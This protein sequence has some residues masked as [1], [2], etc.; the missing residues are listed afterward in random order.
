MNNVDCAGGNSR[1]SALLPS[2]VIFGAVQEIEYFHQ[3]TL[4]A[5]SLFLSQEFPLEPSRF[6]N[7]LTLLEFLRSFPT[8]TFFSAFLTQPIVQF[9]ITNL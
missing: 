7:C 4:M 3:K 1:L 5:F 9:V 8:Q 2:Q 6:T